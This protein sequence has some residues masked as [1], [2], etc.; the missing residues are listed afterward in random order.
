M[1]GAI[2]VGYLVRGDAVNGVGAGKGTQASL[3]S[4]MNGHN[5]IG[6]KG[7]E[8]LG[9][10][11]KLSFDA[12]FQ[13][14]FD[15]GDGAVGG[16]VAPNQ[17][18][19]GSSFRTLYSTLALSGDFGTVVAGRTGGARAAW[20]KK[21]DPFGGFGV[22]GQLAV[23]GGV[24]GGGEDYANN[25]VAWVTPE[26]LPGLKG[27]FAYTSNLD[28]QDVAAGNNA[29]LY[30]IAAMYDAGPVSAVVNYERLN[31]YGGQTVQVMTVGGSYDFGVVKAYGLWDQLTNLGNGY[32]VGLSAPV[33]EA[34]TVKAG[35]ATSERRGGGLFQDA[36]CSKWG[37]GATHALSKRTNLYADVAR[38]SDSDAGSGCAAG[39]TTYGGT[40]GS[41]YGSD[42]QGSGI[43]N[44]ATGNGF[45]KWGANMGIRHTF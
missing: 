43:L 36:E 6:F 32:Q 21:Y 5:G 2:D 13:F 11:M 30:V 18:F 12:F 8:D 41:I 19:N 22:A 26:I 35:Y 27:L 40:H 34:T 4:G 10:G 20:I 39:I 44:G 25:V 3:S 15:S 7:G 14:N 17:G 24:V 16:A 45:G 29:N 28:G 37:L 33:G 38:L 31:S 9:N 23:S 1:Y 42:G